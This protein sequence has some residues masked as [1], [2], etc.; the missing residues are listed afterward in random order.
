MKVTLLIVA[1]LF[2]LCSADYNKVQL[3]EI[4]KVTKKCYNQLNI[5]YESDLVERVIYNRSFSD[6][7]TTKEFINC[8]LVEF[9]VWES[10]GVINRDVVVNFM[11]QQY[12]PVKVRSILNKC[13]RPTGATQ[14]DKAY[15]YARCFFDHLTFEL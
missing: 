5:S 3:A 12:D 15:N 9:N 6:D 8:L 13:F 2:A 14:E 7:P 10:D 1:S 11:A 4:M